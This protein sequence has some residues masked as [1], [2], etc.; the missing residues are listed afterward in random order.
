MFLLFK[1]LSL[2]L[3]FFVMGPTFDKIYVDAY[4]PY[5]RGAMSFENALAWGEAEVLVVLFIVSIY[6]YRSA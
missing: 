6:R 1:T 4:E 5:S 2:F 3:T